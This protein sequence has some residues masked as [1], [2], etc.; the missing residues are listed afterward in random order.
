M[1]SVNF[2]L[3]VLLV[4]FLVFLGVMHRFVF[5][6]LLTIMDK[7]GDQIA[8]DKITAQDA[9]AEAVAL[10]DQYS[11]RIAKMHREASVR[12]NRAHRQAQ[13][14]HNARVVA[15][16]AKA[17]QDLRTLNAAL[18][19]DIARQEDQFE[20]LSRDIHAAMATKLELK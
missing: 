2:T 10:E 14:E 3:F 16:K 9:A 6:P 18:D 1:V 13:E 8:Q 12:L 4:L 11:M 5:L 15:F 7:R 19:A 20:A 17:E